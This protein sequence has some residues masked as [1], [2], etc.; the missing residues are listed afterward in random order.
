MWER[1]KELLGEW[2]IGLIAF[3]LVMAIL[4]LVGIALAGGNAPGTDTSFP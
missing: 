2:A 3:A 4:A 1:L